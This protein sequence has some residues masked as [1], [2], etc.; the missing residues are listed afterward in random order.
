M[1]LYASCYAARQIYLARSIVHNCLYM[2]HIKLLNVSNGAETRDLCI[3]TVKF[4]GSPKG[5]YE[6]YC[7]LDKSDGQHNMMHTAA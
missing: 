1:R 6:R 4:P 5:S 2:F 7:A 3:H